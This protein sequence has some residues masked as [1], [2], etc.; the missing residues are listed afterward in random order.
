MCCR[1]GES[2]ADGNRDAGGRVNGR[3]SPSRWLTAAVES[4][5]L[6]K[7]LRV[8]VLGLVP[9]LAGVGDVGAGFAQSDGDPLPV[10]ALLDVGGIVARHRTIEPVLSA[11]RVD[12]LPH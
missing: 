2:G 4:R 11:M 1:A 12:P 5:A 10:A 8:G 7:S 9:A 6:A 3:C